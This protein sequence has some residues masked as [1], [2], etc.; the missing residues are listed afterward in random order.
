LFHFLSKEF[1]IQLFSTDA[2]ALI[3]KH[4]DACHD[5][6]TMIHDSDQRVT[7]TRKKNEDENKNEEYNPQ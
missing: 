1:T 2:F 3:T 6:L 4:V 5:A 7:G